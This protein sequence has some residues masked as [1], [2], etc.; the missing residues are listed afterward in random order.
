MPPRNIFVQR[1]TASRP[2]DVAP[3]SKISRVFPRRCLPAP[4]V[5][6]FVY[7][8]FFHLEYIYIR[9]RDRLAGGD[10][11]DVS[12]VEFQSCSWR[13]SRTMLRMRIC[14]TSYSAPS[15][16][17]DTSCTGTASLL[18]APERS[19]EPSWGLPSSA[20]KDLCTRPG[21]KSILLGRRAGFLSS[22]FRWLELGATRERKYASMYHMRQGICRRQFLS[23]PGSNYFCFQKRIL[24]CSGLV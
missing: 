23:L 20:N 17:Q 9:I 16:I 6:I 3:A 13:L 4:R 14:L 7:K 2:G 22:S 1:S 24:Y 10:G 21:C 8:A 12:G 18:K 15:L 11:G 19:P 5:H